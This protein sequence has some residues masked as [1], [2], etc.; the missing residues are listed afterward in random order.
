M[1]HNSEDLNIIFQMILTALF[2]LM[3]WFKTSHQRLSEAHSTLKVNF[4]RPPL[5]ILH[6]LTP[7]LSLLAL[8]FLHRTFPLG[9]IYIMRNVQLLDKHIPL[10]HSHIA[11]LEWS[12]T[13]TIKLFKVRWLDGWLMDKYL[14]NL[15]RHKTIH[16][17]I[18]VQKVIFSS[19]H[20]VISICPDEIV[21]YT[22]PLIYS[23]K[24]IKPSKSV[25]CITCFEKRHLLRDY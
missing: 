8:F 13:Y 21:F 14:Q 11:R 17:D 25:F 4:M 7:T 10:L 19:W 23:L 2:S 16:I 24:R 12:G 5:T 18:T 22:I 1:L 15:S 3:H 6:K 9:F 20:Q